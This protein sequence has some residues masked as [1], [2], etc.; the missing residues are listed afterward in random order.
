MVQVMLVTLP[1]R[2]L[3]TAAMPPRAGE[4]VT[5]T[6]VPVYPRPWF[7]IVRLA[8]EVPASVAVAEAPEPPPPVT[9]TAGAAV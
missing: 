2:I 9:E 5:G 3:P 7:V 6:V 1:F 4:N 8:T